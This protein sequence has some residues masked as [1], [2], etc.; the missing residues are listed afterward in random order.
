MD[1]DVVVIGCSRLIVSRDRHGTVKAG[2]TVN[3]AV[4]THG[5]SGHGTQAATRTVA[6]LV[7]Y[8]T[9]NIR[10]YRADIVVV[11]QVVIVFV[12]FVV[13]DIVQYDSSFHQRGFIR[14]VKAK[15]LQVF[16]LCF[17]GGFPT[18]QS[19]MQ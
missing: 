14:F 2:L 7:G 17:V 1:V 3:A 15:F 12:P 11:F 16:F 13:T 8:G 6:A 5:G 19:G 18:R 10:G 9:S 4:G